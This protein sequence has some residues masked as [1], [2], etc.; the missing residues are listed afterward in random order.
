LIGMTHGL[1]LVAIGLLWYGHNSLTPIGW[2]ALLA[3]GAIALV[4]G[5]WRWASMQA[6]GA[7]SS[8]AVDEQ[9]QFEAVGRHNGQRLVLLA[10]AC[11]RLGP[12]V[13]LDVS[14]QPIGSG[15]AAPARKHRLL[16]A[17]DQCEAPSWRKLQAW[18]NWL[19]RSPS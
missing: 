14:A 5:S 16:I 6:K 3:F 19:E 4:L 18:L 1:A 7:F 13:A 9:G 12:L 2:Q 10:L 8:I 17:R 11:R 15:A